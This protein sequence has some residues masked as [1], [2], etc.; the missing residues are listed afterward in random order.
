MDFLQHKKAR[1]TT[2]S[3]VFTTKFKIWP[4][5]QQKIPYLQQHLNTWILN[6][7]RLFTIEKC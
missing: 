7:E 6:I 4:Y 2:G 3:A 1:F 5:S